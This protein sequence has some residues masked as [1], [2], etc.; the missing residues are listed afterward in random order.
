MAKK[1]TKLISAV[2]CAVMICCILVPSALA[3]TEEYYTVKSS[4]LNLRKAPSTSAG[5]IVRLG[6][7]TLV[8]RVDQTLTT[9]NGYEWIHIRDVASGTE[10]Y[11]AK[12]IFEFSFRARGGAACNVVSSPAGAGENGGRCIRVLYRKGVG[13]ESA[14][15]R[16]NELGKGENVWKGRAA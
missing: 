2:I 4:T 7:G 15:R 10:G 3:Q 8:V 14:R 5:R 16:N 6:K 11:V 12:K 13:A 9:K 1:S